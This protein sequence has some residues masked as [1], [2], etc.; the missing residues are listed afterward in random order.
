MLNT[1]MA[2]VNFPFLLNCFTEGREG[3]LLC[4]RGS[5]NF[6][7]EEGFQTEKG[8]YYTLSLAT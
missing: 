4:S 2:Y 5:S 7:L 8:K 3:E 6:H 1:F